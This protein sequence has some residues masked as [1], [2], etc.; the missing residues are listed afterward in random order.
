MKVGACFVVG[1]HHHMIEHYWQQLGAFHWSHLQGLGRKVAGIA[2]RVAAET[3]E[4]WSTLLAAAEYPQAA[5]GAC[6]MRKEVAGCN[7]WRNPWDYSRPSV[8]EVVAVAEAVAEELHTLL[9]ESVELRTLPGHPVAEVACRIAEVAAAALCP[10][11]AGARRTLPGVAGVPRIHQDLAVGGLVGGEGHKAQEHSLGQVVVLHTRGQA[12][13]LRNLL[14]GLQQGTA[15]LL[16]QDTFLLQL[17]VGRHNLEGHLDAQDLLVLGVLRIGQEDHSGG[18]RTLAE[19]HRTRPAVLRS[20]QAP[21]GSLLL[22]PAALGCC[23]LP[24]LVI[25]R[26]RFR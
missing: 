13:V 11:W 9:G 3:A 7:P 15:P 14:E 23:T 19:P 24:Q 1:I 20:H 12:Q 25:H 4:A 6:H 26:A 2:G 18:R 8:G 21:P 16:L 5:V 10:G 22:L 17:P